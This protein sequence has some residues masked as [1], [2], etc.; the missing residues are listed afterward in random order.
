MSDPTE[1]MAVTPPDEQDTL[2]D[3]LGVMREQRA[4][5]TLEDV[6]LP[7]FAGRLWARFRLPQNQVKATQLGMLMV[8]GHENATPS[9]V[10]LL[11]ECTVGLF[12]MTDPNAESPVYADGGSLAPG[13]S[14]LPGGMDEMP[15]NF[16]DSRLE[17]VQGGKLCPPRPN[18]REHSP[19]TR[20][21]SLFANDA[22]VVQAATLI[23]GWALGGGDQQG[24]LADL[25]ARFR[26]GDQRE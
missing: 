11:T 1:I 12:L 4:A 2:L 24:A 19:E 16:K 14:H 26:E 18:G 25:S 6:P 22:L 17:R 21:R 13:F 7:G 9:A 8:A 15:V 5:E 23:C 3:A 10:A 20:V